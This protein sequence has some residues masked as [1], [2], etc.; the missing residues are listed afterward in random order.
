MRSTFL[1][2][3]FCM[4]LIAT[5]GVSNGVLARSDEEAV[6]TA[7]LADEQMALLGEDVDAAQANLLELSRIIPPDSAV[8]QDFRP[9]RVNVDLDE[10]GMIIRVWCG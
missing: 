2:G 9:D 6:Q 4:V 3:L 5:L 1:S 8:T 7:C 10:D